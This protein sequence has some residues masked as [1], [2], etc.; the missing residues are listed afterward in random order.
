MATPE[1]IRDVRARIGNA[2]LHVPTVGVLAYDPDGRVLLVQDAQSQLWTCPGGIVE[3]FEL[4]ADAA[5]RETWE[6]AGV[7]V[8]LTGIIGV[9]GGEH[10]GG[11]YANGDRIAWVATIFSAR[12]VRGQPLPDY[13]E[14][15]A[16]CFFSPEQTAELRLKPHLALFLA[17]AR[18]TQ[19]G[20]FQPATWV[21]DDAETGRSSADAF[22]SGMPHDQPALPDTQPLQ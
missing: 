21:P 6:E 7:Q 20:Y 19:G 1:F 9:F 16:A 11:T 14:T 22:S 12:V 18:S 3:P 13:S 17:A 2:L 5:V 10:C 8:E 15:T 4:P